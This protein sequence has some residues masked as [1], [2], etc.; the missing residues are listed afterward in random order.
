MRSAGP[1]TKDETTASEHR[2][3]SQAF[4]LSSP[5]CR[6]SEG[7]SHNS[8]LSFHRLLINFKLQNFI[9]STSRD[10]QIARA[11]GR[12]TDGRMNERC[13]YPIG[14]R[15]VTGAAGVYLSLQCRVSEG[16]S[17]N[18]HSS[19]HRFLVNL[20]MQNFTGSTSRNSQI[21]QT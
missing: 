10:S 7:A 9:W 5:Q 21:A 17:H 12:Q 19:F 11:S 20:A 18:S 6:I 3:S 14:S 16:A 15:V 8:H 4:F 2:V 13:N 1:G